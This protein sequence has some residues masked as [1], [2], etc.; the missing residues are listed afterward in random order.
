MPYLRALGI[1]HLYASPYL[2]AAA[3]SSHGYDVVDPTRVN[4]E[5]GGPDGHARLCTSL[6]THGIGQVID[7]VPNHLA[8]AGGRNPW[9][10]DV[11]EKG[12]ASRYAGFFDIDWQGSGDRWSG[13][14]LLPVLDDQYGRVLE[15]GR[16]HVSRENGEFV[17][18]YADHVFPLSPSSLPGL[19]NESRSQTPGGDSDTE[20]WGD[21]DIEAWVESVNGDP[22]ALHLLLEKQHYRL[23]YWRTA[24]SELNYRRFFDITGL[25]GLRVEDEE[26]FRSVH[27]LPFKWYAEGSV[28]GIRVDHPDGLWDPT[29]YFDRMREECP[30]AYIVAE[31]ILGRGEPLPGVWPIAGTTGYE[32]LNLVG[33][34]FID[35]DG[36]T[37]MTRIYDDL[38]GAKTDFAT[39]LVDCKRLVL[40]ELFGSELNRLTRLFGAVCEDH[41]RHR[42][43]TY[44]DLRAALREAVACFPVYR[45]YVSAGR[46]EVTKVDENYIEQ[47]L[48]VAATERTDIDPRLF[49]FLRDLL[50][51]RVRGSL[52]GE[53]AMRFQQLTSPAMAKGLEDT[54]LYRYQRFVALNEV[55]GDPSRFGTTA[56]DF[57]QVCSAAEAQH[58]SGLLATD[59]HD[60]K[61]SGDVRA[62]LA[63]LS[64]VPQEWREAVRRWT[65][66]NRRHRRDDLPDANTEYLLYQTLVGAWPVDVSRVLAYMEKAVREAKMYTSWT[67][68]DEAYERL[69][70][71]FV[72]GVMEDDVFRSELETFV[73]RVVEPG[74][75]N[76]LAQTLIKLTAPGVPDIYQGTELWD[77]SLVDPDNRRPV[78][79]ARRR[80]LL[81]EVESLMPEDVLARAD[82]GLP[83][84]WLVQRTLHF[85][86][87]NPE[88]F[89]AG[90]SY[91]PLPA[92]GPRSKHALAFI[93]GD[94]VITIVPRFPVRLGGDW[95][96]TTLELPGGPNGIW[97]N[98]LTGEQL[99]GGTTLLG[100]L[101]ARFPVALL[102]TD[103]EAGGVVDD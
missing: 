1:S 62:R 76:S 95:K 80:R 52:E 101:T 32:F 100:D 13:K 21:S 54:A 4:D 37:Y 12:Q 88:F 18:R 99:P 2:Q 35:P 14:V 73:E 23:A 81:S 91:R 82:E 93:R 5:L 75:I 7:L 19:A 51:L 65:Q 56:D 17:L 74:R 72:A 38:V 29:Q 66:H 40:D 70:A 83:K 20:A 11:L 63:V 78:D 69:L 97:R 39:V 24:A 61:R 68:V 36:E 57:H 15:A 79:F 27:V 34:L 33:G 96:D 8:V 103:S 58:Q 102:T 85:R 30:E 77:L 43:Y 45:S 87:D 46:G 55:G 64:E 67:R 48:A 94:R 6:K 86:R 31:K 50:R 25:A 92:R 47:A 53:L 22:D 59:T 49:E 90:A 16:L 42:D 71:D 44:D 84:L 89:S 26:V 9:W 98:V 41:R 10:W 28:Q 3:G 60:T